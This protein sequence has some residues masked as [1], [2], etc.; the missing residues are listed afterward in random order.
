MSD[1]CNLRKV[2]KKGPGPAGDI[3]DLLEETAPLAD[4][5]PHAPRDAGPGS[6]SLAGAVFRGVVDNVTAP[7]EDD[8]S[9]PVGLLAVAKDIIM[10]LLLAIA[11]LAVMVYLDSHDV[12]HLESAHTL[13]T[14]AFAM[15]NDPETLVNVQEAAGLKFLPMSEYDV[16]RRTVDEAP[17]TITNAKETLQK[18]QEE[19]DEKMKG[20]DS[21]RAEHES[22]L[23]NPLLGLDKYCGNCKWNRKITCD[24]RKAFLM[25]KYKLKNIKATIGAMDHPSCIK[26]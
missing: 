8:D 15:L 23:K 13:R 16:M 24:A 12:V 26:N 6:A 3:E 5:L 7:D 21:L 19:M 18:K 20:V 22:L 9:Q 1:T 14:M 10:G 25:K 2:T 17:E 11:L 4:A